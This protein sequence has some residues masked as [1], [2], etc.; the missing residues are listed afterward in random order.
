[1]LQLT[2]P[3]RPSNAAPTDEEQ[4]N[5]ATAETN[6]RRGGATACKQIDAP[7]WTFVF[8]LSVRGGAGLALMTDFL[9]HQI[10]N[11]FSLDEI[12]VRR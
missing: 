4:A 11:N 6:Q 10:F 2:Q 3:T 12:S 7:R 1:M 5:A 8:C 9:S